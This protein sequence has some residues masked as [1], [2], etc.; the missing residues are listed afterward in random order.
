MRLAGVHCHIGSQVW[1]LTSYARAMQIVVGVVAAASAQIGA[2][3]GELNI[4]GGLGIAYHAG[5]AAPTIREY[6]TVVRQA[7]DD[8]CAGAGLDPRPRL[9]VEPGRSIAG[10]A[11]LT[12]YRVGTIKN[13]PS[14]RTYVAVDGG[15]S[16]NPRP[17]TYGARYEA[18]LPT[19]ADAERPF[20]ATVA[21]KHCEQGD[22]LVRDAALPDGVAVGDVLAMPATGG[23]AYS[24]A[25]NYNR[26]PRPAV[27][28]VAGGSARVVVRRE[29][30]DDL[31][32]LDQ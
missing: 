19:R 22:L 28:F 7:F 1:N 26:V 18:F 4:G 17:V 32:R 29:S 12:L 20:V 30:L 9:M 31:L 15:M 8:A 14:V 16:D 25:S 24:M 13:V 11:G 5:D 21:G 23:Y 2:A 6:A 10:P 3:L 27:V